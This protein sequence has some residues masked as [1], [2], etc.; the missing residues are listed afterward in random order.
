MKIL[1]LDLGTNSIGW[2]IRDTTENGNQIIN[3]GVLTFDK[4]VGEG[5]SGEFPLVQKRTESRGK[6]RNYQAE[7]YRKWELLKTLIEAKMCPLTFN[8][9]ND[10]RHYKKGVGRK[11]PQSPKFIEWL[12]F[13]FDGDGKPDFERLG[14]SKHESLYIFRMLA[15]KEDNQFKNIFK[16][17]PQILGRVLYQLVQRRGF[18]GRDEEESKTIMNGGGESGAK[19]VNEIE[20]FIREYGTL[21]S[22]LYY[23]QKEKGERIRKRYNLRSHYEQ[24]LQHICK[25]HG[26]DKELY[27]RFWKAII[28][29]RPL[30]SQKGL[31]G[32]CTF[33]PNKSRAQLSH[34]FYEEYR[35][36]VFINNLKIIVPDGYTYEEYIQER[37]YPLFINSLRDFKLK[38]ILDRLRKDGGRIE[39]KFKENTKVISCTLHYEFEK[40]FGQNW[41]DNYGWSEALNNKPKVIPYSI[42]DIWHVLATFDSSEKLK[43]FA[44]NKLNLASEEAERFSKIHLQQG[45]ATLSLAVI[46]KL[47]PYLKKGFKYSH[48]VYLGN[49]HKVLGAKIL[50]DK[51]YTHLSEIF[52]G[53]EFEI[54]QERTV[55]EVV[56]SLISDH[57]NATIRWG[58]DPVYQLDSDDKKDI[59]NKITLIIGA[60]SW[61]EKSEREK[62]LIWE[63]VSNKYQHYLQQ[64]INTPLHNIF[65]KQQRL[66]DKIF[67]NLQD[68]YDL[69]DEAIRKLWH[70]SE[71]EGYAAAPIKNGMKIL[72]NPQPI[73]RGFKNPMALKTLH[74]LK[75]LIN[76]LLVEGKIDEDTRIVIE[77]ARELNDGNK[78]K[79]IERWQKIREKENEEISKRIEETIKQFNLSIDPYDK[80]I[81]DKYRLWVE[82]SER[83]I[84]T[85][86]TINAS[87]LFNGS[88][89][90][91]EHTVP[92]S[93]SF[94]NELKNLTLA[95]GLYNKTIK[96]KKLPTE[97]P[98]YDEDA[99]INGSTYTA[100]KPRL[101][102]LKDKVEALEDLL[103]EWKKKTSDT[104]NIK[105]AIIQRRHIIKMDLD[106]WKRK[107]ETFTIQ[108]YKV[109]W[110]NSQLRDTQVITK[111][112]LPYLK[113]VFNKV[114]VQKGSVTSA[115]RE[116]YKI[117]PRMEKKSR[118][119]HSHH[120]IDAAVLTL[121]P[122][123]QIRDK[124]LL[125]YNEEKDKNP[126]NTY[127]ELPR[128]WK[129][130]SANYI[131]NMEDEMLINFQ[132]QFRTLT[133]TYR[134]VRKRGKQQYLKQKD[135]NGQ[136]H[137]TLNNNGNKIPLVAKGDSIR[138]QLHKESFFG[139][140][141]LNGEKILIER[142]PISAFTKIED[143][144]NIVDK[145]VSNI[146]QEVLKERIANGLTFDKAKLEPIRFPSGKAIIKK[147]RCKV[148]A[149]RGFLT[150]EKALKIKSVD[151]PSKYDYKNFV[152]A[153]NKENTLCL[154][155]EGEI[156][157]KI[158][159]SFKII[160]LFELAQTKI[161]RIKEIYDEPFYNSMEV[162]K[163]KINANIPL[164]FIIQVGAKV[165]F[166]KEKR[167]ELVEIPEKELLRRVF[168]VY[169][170]NEMG[171]PY[172][173]LQNHL[174]AR[175]NDQLGDGDTIF[176]NTRYQHRLKLKADKFTAIIEGKDFNVFPDGSIY[177][178]Y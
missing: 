175:P 146:V 67:K 99:V 155:Y 47:I 30:R 54:K 174:E 33:E 38:K 76:H 36:L 158:S 97:L 124:I 161:K 26:L 24:E 156:E 70:P 28:W 87:D 125:R 114:D 149:G 130:F 112:A 82:Q 46:K 95:D 160:G 134:N 101:K 129:N 165:I 98:N 12:R 55:N 14:I 111:Y 142:Y 91:I 58:M 7:K 23:L 3:K 150:P 154:F 40:L 42:E 177:F 85:G 115:F 86:K 113:T 79:A 57:Q 133:E 16:N 96:G 102:F 178:N 123:F 103:D 107:L 41:K 71:Q 43:E 176:D 51:M 138:G 89:Y 25:I 1:G 139:A 68:I 168:R 147:V 29:Q 50:D 94:D 128:D 118:D 173:Y 90:D 104:K 11:Y 74:M 48:A 135:L 151:F 105:D 116:I 75:K 81:I 17:E 10:W 167:E 141:K 169:K 63:A 171:S 164:R 163:G 92:A 153:Q 84:Y 148:A 88:L 45:F 77:I 143:C 93:M 53:I 66:H 5:K 117:Q 59:E 140:I 100:I 120:A 144:K 52:D 119:K 137:F 22:A 72:G 132:P 34:P 9:L 8:D 37:I 170:F 32:R 35:A 61:K 136:W 31:I 162:K 78:R 80:E 4:G 56:F 159:R 157:N 69:P 15:S 60:M 49:M 64:H 27:K 19:G 172:I 13:D 126:F 122:P 21:G 121:I 127:H 131:L 62:S 65:P 6:R 145:T 152:Y 20:P 83:C 44:I 108:E 73:S 106:Y 2:A 18:R 39:S 109:G 110:R 166:Y